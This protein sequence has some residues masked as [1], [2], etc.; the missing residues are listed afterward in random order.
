MQDPKKSLDFY[1]KHMGMTLLAHQDY[2][3]F[4]LYYLGTVPEGANEFPEGRPVLELTHNHGT[5][6]EAEFSYL[7]GNEADRK[8]FGH[9]GFLVD[10]VARAIS[11][12]LGWGIL[13]YTILYYTILYYTILYYTILYYTILYYTILYYTILYDTIRY[14]TIPYDTILYHTILYYTILYYTILYY[15]ILY[16]TILYYTVL[17]CTIL[18]Y[19]ILYYTI[20]YYTILY[21][22]SFVV[23]I[24]LM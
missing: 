17:Y 1:T 21:G 20:L 19:T 4:S 16:Y 10:D 9:V 13:Y 14:H 12:T 15:T 8:G 6:D 5:E 23:S 11:R 18:Y 2:D 7:S 3:D 22:S 24:L